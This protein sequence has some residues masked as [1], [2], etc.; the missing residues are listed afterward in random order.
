[1][2]NTSFSIEAALPFLIPVIVIQ[3]VLV[4]FALID[5]FKQPNVRGP[6]W[7][8]LILILFVQMIGPILYFTIGRKE[9]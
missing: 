5:F 6:R 3:F 2:N 8:W 9:E 1:M 7:L 4:V